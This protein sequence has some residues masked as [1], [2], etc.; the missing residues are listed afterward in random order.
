MEDDNT[1]KY[2]TNANY[3]YLILER[4]FIKTNEAI[5]KIGKTKQKNL[6]RVKQYPKNSVLLLQKICT[7]CDEAERSLLKIFT[8]KYKQRTDIGREY[9]EG[10]YMQMISDI[11]KECRID[12]SKQKIYT[13][14]E[15]RTGIGREYFEG[16][17]FK[18]IYTCL[19]SDLDNFI[20]DTNNN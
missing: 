19:E 13:R 4:E 8:E 5:F 14:T 7:N 20:N 10:D 17:Y 18:G 3:I 15:Q 9:F 6:T 2:I 11:E 16:E 1:M 12:E